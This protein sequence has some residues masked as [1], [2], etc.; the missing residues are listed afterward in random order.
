[1]MYYLYSSTG[2]TLEIQ[3]YIGYFQMGDDGYCSRYLEINTD[4]TTLRYTKDHPADS[5]GQLP[6][7]N[8]EDHK[9]EMS[10]KEY[11]VTTPV[12]SALF[13]AVWE[14]TSCANQ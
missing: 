2:N 4:G 1:M 10:K 6:E 5:F 12:T 8:W 3:E 13:N 14:N 11:G 7:G 9:A